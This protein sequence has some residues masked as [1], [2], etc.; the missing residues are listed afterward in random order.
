MPEI[1]RGGVQSSPNEQRDFRDPTAIAVFLDLDGT[2][3]DLAE[4]PSGVTVTQDLLSR[5]RRLHRLLDGAVAIVS[6]RPIID[7]DRLLSPL[8]LPVAG[9]HG[10]ERRSAL[11]DYHRSALPA[12]V[13]LEFLRRALR[14]I[15]DRHPGTLLEDKTYSLAL[16]FRKNPE[17]G[18]AICSSI[19]R[20]VD[21][22]QGEFECQ[23]GRFVMEVR[24]RS[25]TKG[26]AVAAFMRERPFAGRT[27]LV[28]GD[29][30]TDESSFAVA[31]QLGGI[32][33]AVAPE[34]VT[35]ATVTLPDVNAMHAWLDTLLTQF[36][37]ARPC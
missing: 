23:P 34:H 22:L 3:L 1:D 6:G 15:A 32:S 30:L 20:A 21:S 4:T 26:R 16:H 17:F 37:R 24:P 13:Q 19:E 33:I 11:G 8:Q 31:N 2:L 9:L 14:G 28:A 5:L 7:V 27:P 35:A 36:A 18:A 10:F 25:A 12:G 29:D